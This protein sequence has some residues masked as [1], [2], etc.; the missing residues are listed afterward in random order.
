[1]TNHDIPAH[2]RNT[3][4]IIRMR[5]LREK[6]KLSPSHLYSLISK[7]LFPAPFPLIQGGRATGWDESDIDNYLAKLGG[8]K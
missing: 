4:R 6:L 2:T 1:M 7:G 5:E 8:K 3:T